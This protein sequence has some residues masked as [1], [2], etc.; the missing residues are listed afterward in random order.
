MT[1]DRTQLD[2]IEVKV[3]ELHLI[4]KT[5]LEG[6]GEAQNSSG[7]AGMMARQLPDVSKL[8]TLDYVS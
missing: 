6:I 2:R 1:D 5:L 8:N 3:N 4:V 7:M